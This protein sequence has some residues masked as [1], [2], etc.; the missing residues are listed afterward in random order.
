[1]K[2]ISICIIALILGIVSMLAFSEIKSTVTREKE[3]LFVRMFYSNP[4]YARN[5]EVESYLLTN[6]QVIQLLTNP[7]AK[8]QQP[9]LKDLYLKNVNIVL[10]IKNNGDE[11]AWGTVGYEFKYDNRKKI[12][13][14]L[15]SVHYSKNNLFHEYIIPA[16]VKIYDNDN[17]LPEP[18]EIKWVAL[19]TKPDRDKLDG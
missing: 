2:K 8:I 15:P 17:V 6:E 3:S 9:V 4:E 1:M 12:D 11:V 14:E 7:Q 13:V 5:V 18:L 10:R 16:G 19:Y